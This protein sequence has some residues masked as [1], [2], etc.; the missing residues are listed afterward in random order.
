MGSRPHLRARRCPARRPALTGDRAPPAPAAVS[1]AETVCT[2][3][4]AGPILAIGTSPPATQSALP[5][6]RT[7]VKTGGPGQPV[8]WVRI[9]SPPL[10]VAVSALAGDRDLV[11]PA[12]RRTPPGRCQV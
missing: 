12:A 4:L 1:I 7:R 10:V 3:S 9:P 5:R 2:D 11:C 6:R 8:P